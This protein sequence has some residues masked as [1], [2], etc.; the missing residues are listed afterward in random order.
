MLV[1]F[2]PGGPADILAR[3]IALRMDEGFGRR[4]IVDNRPGANTIIGSNAVI[5]DIGLKIESSRLQPQR[6]RS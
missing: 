2:P 5:K 6:R 4:V 1:P 3:V